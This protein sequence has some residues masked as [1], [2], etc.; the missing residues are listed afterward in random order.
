MVN[1]RKGT[2]AAKSSKDVL[3]TQIL[4]T[5]MHGV[6]IG[7]LCFKSTPPQ[8]PYRLLLEKSQA[9]VFDRLYEPVQ[10]DVDSRNPAT[11]LEHA[12][13]APESH[14]SNMDSDDLDDVPL[15]RLLKKNFV[16]DVV[17]EKYIDPPILVH[18]QESSST[19]GVF[20]PTPSLQHTLNVEPG[21]SLYSSP[22]RSSIPKNTTTSGPHNDS[23]PAF[24][25]ESIATEGRTDVHNGEDEV[26]PANTGD[27]TGEISIDDNNNPAA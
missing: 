11:N 1:T 4:K 23:A 17:A 25:D 3:E 5:S 20:V 26:E 24:A 21:P 10:D 15:A 13:G 6:S 14:M 2:Y 16:L 8:R 19:E 7:G 22:V 12:P 9:H 27:H 18:S